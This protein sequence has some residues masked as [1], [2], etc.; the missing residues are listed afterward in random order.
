MTVSPRSFAP[1]LLLAIVALIATAGPAAAQSYQSDEFDKRLSARGRIAARLAK[2]PS[3]TAEEQAQ[4]DAYMDNYLFPAMTQYTPKELE[5]L[6]KLRYDLFKQFLWAASPATQKKLSDKASKF[7]VKV[8]S[9]RKYHPSVT[10]NAL[11]IL[12]MLDSKYATSAN[13]TPTPN[14]KSNKL[15]STLAAK[16]ATNGRYPRYWLVASLTGLE[17]HCQYFDKLPKDQQTAT[18]KALIGILIAKELPG[19][20]GDGVRDWVV[21]QAAQAL[22][23]IGD[24]GPKGRRMLAIAKRVAD[25]SLELRTRAGLASLLNEFEDPKG[26]NAAPVVNAVKDLLLAIAER[27]EKFAERFEN[28]QLRRQGGQAVGLPSRSGEGHR[29][30][31]SGRREVVLVREGLLDVMQDI[32]DALAAV[33]PLAEGETKT[34]FESIAAA[35]DL[36]IKQISDDE[37][38]DLSIA[39]GVREMARTVEDAFSE[40]AEEEEEPDF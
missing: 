21:T 29:I 10:Y 17:R 16:A 3:L 13:P 25:D 4:F 11:L 36:V 23:N 32:A 9:S 20:Y 6:G 40:A 7:A 14:A 34:D 19:D 38:I 5:S 33:T 27:E 18:E 35:L 31:Q 37:E 8:V 15:L 24:A 30:R 26:L 2:Q 39:A 1:K 28:S 12:G 22:A